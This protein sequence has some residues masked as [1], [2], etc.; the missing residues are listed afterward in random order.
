M[1]VQKM[2]GLITGKG[3]NQGKVKLAVL[4]ALAAV[5]LFLVITVDVPRTT[6]E[7]CNCNVCHG[8]AVHGSGWQG[9]ASCHGFPP[10][11]AS[12]LKHFEDADGILNK[13]QSYGATSLAQDYYPDPNTPAGSYLMGCGN[14]HPMDNAKH[15]NGA[16]DVE[17]YNAAA[18]AG[19]LK[20]KNPASASYTPGNTVYYDDKNLPYTLGACNNVYCHSYNEWATPGGVLVTTRKYKTLTWG[21]ES[22]TCSGC[23]ENP[24]TTRYPAN[25]NGAGD[26]HQYIDDW[27]YGWRHNWNHDDRQA[28][29]GCVYCHSDTVKELNYPWTYNPD[30][31][32]MGDV[33]VANYSK[34]VNGTA[35]VVFEKTNRFPYY[36]SSGTTY[37]NSGFR[38][39]GTTG[40]FY[41]SLLQATYD[42]ATKTCSNVGCHHNVESTSG[43]CSK[44]EYFTQ[45]TCQSN[46]GVWTAG[47]NVA[48]IEQ[49]VRW[50]AQ[51]SGWSGCSKC[52]PY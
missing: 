46:G 27:G 29:L 47:V 21:G 4:L 15:Q 50:G 31:K 40:Y 45:A 35:D 51:V 38:Y 16:V 3:G 32:T 8:S 2:R 9:C 11:T 23:H 22:L 24:P 48:L 18:P 25:V 30:F 20:A 42:P 5:G 37:S 14:C 44:P 33:P 1:S 41:P 12:H 39:A 7:D 6:A 19:S 28:P 26:S 13:Y 36:A 43:K 10:A 17:F 52:H 49:S 34:H